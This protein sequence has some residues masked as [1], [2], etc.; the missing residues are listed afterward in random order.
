[1][2]QRAI[3]ILLAG[4][5]SIVPLQAARADARFNIGLQGSNAFS[6][7]M[8][9][10][11][12]GAVLEGYV[13]FDKWLGAGMRIFYHHLSDGAHWTSIQILS[14]IHPIDP[15]YGWDLYFGGGLG[16]GF[17]HNESTLDVVTRAGLDYWLTD[18]FGA[19]LSGDYVLSVGFDSTNPTINAI[20][21][22]V[23]SVNGG[24]RFR[25]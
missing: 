19:T 9:S 24:I 5:L 4:C 13:R 10:N 14:D 16:D 8:G 15:E 17:L 22:R 1:M 25:F 11:N 2:N 12:P 7:T 21:M 20:R 18:H 6:N 3:W 23:F